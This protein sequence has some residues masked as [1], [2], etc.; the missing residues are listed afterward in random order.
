MAHSEHGSQLLRT[1]R[2]GPLSVQKPFYPEGRDCCHLYLLHPPAG[3]VSG[4]TLNVIVNVQNNAHALITTPGANRFYRARTDKTIGDSKQQQTTTINLSDGGVC[5]HFPLETIVYNQADAVNKVTVNLHPNSTYLGWDIS[6][7]G[8]PSSDEQFTQ[9]QFVQLNQ[10]VLPERLVFHDRMC[11]DTNLDILTHS[12]GLAQ[13]SVFGTFIAHAPLERIHQQSIDS[14]VDEMRALVEREQAQELVSITAI[15]QLVLI[16]YL[17]SHAQQCKDLFVL[18]REK[19][20]PVYIDKEG[21]Q[22]RIWHT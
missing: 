10:V 14:L 3:I 7:M 5:E 19:L 15:K 16:R 6:C 11:I 12:A 17:G 20:R 1:K 21:V 13:K 8:L 9:G 22:P 2:K 18:L 4:D